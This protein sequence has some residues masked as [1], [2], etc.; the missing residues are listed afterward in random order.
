MKQSRGCVLYPAF[1]FIVAAHS[2]QLFRAHARF[3]MNTECRCK[4]ILQTNTSA[5]S[6]IISPRGSARGWIV[7]HIYL[8][9]L[10]LEH[11][12]AK[13]LPIYLP[14][15][16]PATAF[17]NVVII[18]VVLMYNPFALNS[19]RR[20]HVLWCRQSSPA[21]AERNRNVFRFECQPTIRQEHILF[22]R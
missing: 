11:P 9:V 7:E 12:P 22:V 1:N 20:R 15:R 16:F 14:P 18:I 4:P 13:V 19:L 3:V 5:D 10:V 8:T 21:R 17:S 6:R 2:A